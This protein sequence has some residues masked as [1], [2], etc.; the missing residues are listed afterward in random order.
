[1]STASP[2]AEN[3]R[4]A[5]GAHLRIPT[6]ELKTAKEIAARRLFYIRTMENGLAEEM[7]RRITAENEAAK[8]RRCVER[9]Q[10]E[11]H[12]LGDESGPFA[13]EAPAD[14]EGRDTTVD[15]SFFR[16]LGAKSDRTRD[17]TSQESFEEA[18][19]AEVSARMGRITRER[20]LENHVAMR[21]V[22]ER[23]SAY[24]RD[25]RKMLNG[26]DIISDEES[27]PGGETS[28]DALKRRF[29]DVEG[30]ESVSP[31]PKKVKTSAATDQGTK[32]LL[33]TSKAPVKQSKTAEKPSET[34]L[35]HF[36]TSLKKTGAPVEQSNTPAKKVKAPVKQSET[37]VKHSKTPVKQAKTPAKQSK[38]PVKNAKTPVK[39]T[40]TPVKTAKTHVKQSPVQ[41]AIRS[42]LTR[43]S[44]QD[45]G[46]AIPNPF[47]PSLQKTP[48]AKK[49][50]AT[51]EAKS[52]QASSKTPK[53][54]VSFSKAAKKSSPASVK[55]GRVVK[56][57]TI[58][59]KV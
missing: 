51:P 11:E 56:S 4:T 53:K 49:A 37:P 13:A 42:V 18:V 20:W 50:S 45:Q 15:R 25:M 19:E 54:A 16:P 57:S 55:Q 41:E 28:L 29:S 59:R 47:A 36:K 34:A 44:A 7:E 6:D 27:S 1:M 35:K 8:L 21:T 24:F 3:P 40:K 12:P 5:W 17:Q 22:R 38:T 23:D 10:R 26:D 9:L 30:E 39:T 43:R 58:R 32:A 14:D 2:E 33:V 46:I 48:V 52:K 31:S